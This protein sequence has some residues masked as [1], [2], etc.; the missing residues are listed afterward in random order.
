[1]LLLDE[2]ASKTVQKEE[3]YDDRFKGRK[4]LKEG[5]FTRNIN[6]N[7]QSYRIINM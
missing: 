1:M 2:I 7:P 3:D 4:I 6:K 5:K